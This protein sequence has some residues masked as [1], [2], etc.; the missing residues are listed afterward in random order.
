MGSLGYERRED[1][2]MQLARPFMGPLSMTMSWRRP[3]PDAL[4]D[5]LEPIAGVGGLESG[6][7]QA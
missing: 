3:Y 4:F 7:G 2:A 5:A 6:T 1:M